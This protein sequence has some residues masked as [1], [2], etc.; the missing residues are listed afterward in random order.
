MTIRRAVDGLGRT[1]RVAPHSSAGFGSSAGLGREA[2]A[3]S[4]QLYLAACVPAL[5]ST[6]PSPGQ[7]TEDSVISYEPAFLARSSA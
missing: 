7:P 1:G 2:S 4:F 5:R 6:F 3:L